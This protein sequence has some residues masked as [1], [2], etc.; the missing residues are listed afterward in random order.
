MW[1]DIS[2][3]KLRKFLI[4]RGEWVSN[5]LIWIKGPKLNTNYR[6]VPKNYQRN[7]L[8]KKFEESFNGPSSFNRAFNPAIISLLYNT[9][10]RKDE[11]VRLNFTD[12]NRKD[13]TLKVFGKKVGVERVVPVNA[14]T[15][16][17]LENY[18][19]KRSE[20]LIKKN[21]Q[22]EALFVNRNGSRA[23]DS[24]IY[25]QIKSV[26]K[27]AGVT[28]ASTHMFRHSCATDMVENGA[29][30][31]TVKSILGHSH[32]V[33]TF[34]Y[35]NVADPERQKAMHLHPINSILDVIS[36]EDLCIK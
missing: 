14:V 25:A 27:R 24:Q 3:E 23:K 7:Q 1:S 31:Q 36:K 11:L 35:L 21:T 32:I 26:A 29:S 6:K 17:C 19:S 15:W 9:G 16:K 4:D 2:D 34:R 10:L 30:I 13:L 8:K 22:C 33:T 28:N 18:L 5:P 12:W 20:I